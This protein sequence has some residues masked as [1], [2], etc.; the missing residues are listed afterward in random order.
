[1]TKPVMMSWRMIALGKVRMGR[2]RVR[3]IQGPL[4]N[5]LH[6]SDVV[7]SNGQLV[8]RRRVLRSSVLR[9]RVLWSGVL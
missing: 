3:G 4:S 2:T 6:P 8:L 5:N 7:S 1:M 9:S